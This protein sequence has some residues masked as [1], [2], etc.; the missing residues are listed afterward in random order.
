MAKDTLKARGVDLVLLIMAEGG[1]CDGTGKMRVEVGPCK[2]F[3]MSTIN[4]LRR[5]GYKVTEE[6]PGQFFYAYPKESN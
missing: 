6:I 2:P 4:T 5:R 1:N 3:S